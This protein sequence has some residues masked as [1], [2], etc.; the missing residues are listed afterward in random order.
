MS[1][2]CVSW[3]QAL[4]SLLGFILSTA[5]LMSP[6][7]QMPGNGPSPEARLRPVG[8]GL[9]L[10]LIYGLLWM[11][12]VV[13]AATLSRVT[14]PLRRI[15]L[16]GVRGCGRRRRLRRS[17]PGNQGRGRPRGASRRVRLTEAGASYLDDCRLILASL[18]EAEQAVMG[19]AASPQGWL[20][21]TAP[22]LSSSAGEPR[23][24]S[25]TTQQPASAG[26][27]P[28]RSATSLIHPILRHF[29]FSREGPALARPSQRGTLRSKPELPSSCC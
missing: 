24:T 1:S 23:A 28:W 7:K 10:P 2:L 6:V 8:L 21:L 22:V 9:S 3:S 19:A 4:R 14:R 12:P 27:S 13:P 20:H 29:E 17:H 25:V 26:G 5:L 15:P 11:T 18:D 16:A